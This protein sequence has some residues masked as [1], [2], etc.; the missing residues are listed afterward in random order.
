MTK[1]QKKPFEP[2]TVFDGVDKM[3]KAFR[4]MKNPV[5]ADFILDRLIVSADNGD[6]TCT[7]DRNI[8]LIIELL[9]KGSTIKT[10]SSF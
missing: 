8:Q 6:G 1:G 4:T 3:K 9:V 2:R 7:I 10:S 5:D